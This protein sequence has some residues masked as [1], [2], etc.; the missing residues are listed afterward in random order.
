MAVKSDL[1]FDPDCNR[2][3]FVLGKGSIFNSGSNFRKEIAFVGFYEGPY[4]SVMEAQAQLV[5][6]TWASGTRATTI[7][8]DFFSPSEQ[9]ALR[10][11]IKMRNLDV[12]QFWMSDYV[13]LVEEISRE[14]GIERNDHGFQGQSGPAFPARYAGP[15]CDKEEAKKV[16]EEVRNV[17]KDSK[18]KGRFAA[19]ATFRGMQ[20]TWTLERKIDSR[21]ASM[22]GGT[23]K[24][25]AQF[26]PRV[27]TNPTYSAE[28]LY[29]E[30]GILKMDNGYTFPA[31]RR[32][33]YRYNETTDA[34]TAWFTADDGES[35]GN[36]FNKWEFQKPQDDEHGWI[37][38]GSHWCSP[39]T[40]K[41]SCEFRFRGASLETFGIT[42]EATGPNKD[43]THESWYRRPVKVERDAESVLPMRTK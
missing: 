28:Y 3:P 37:A 32:Y 30:E 1:Q 7:E 39:D 11:D 10:V 22:P 17:L 42:Y 33:V 35:V 36:F 5:A 8:S 21:L 13:G 29:T 20:G 38:K 15:G 27:P 34:I 6:Q 43:Y 4:W 9:V 26:H 16:L 24:G 2:L 40:Y 31:T 14:A 41:N 18:E 23:Y 12:P 19:A 25:T